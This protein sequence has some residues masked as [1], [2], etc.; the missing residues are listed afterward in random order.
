MGAGTGRDYEQARDR[1]V[2]AALHAG[3]LIAR[4]AGQVPEDGL[5]EKVHHD[6]VTLVDEEA[7]RL[8]LG[9]LHTAYPHDA[10]LAEEGAGEAV[11]AAAG[12]RWIID[13]IDG[14]ANFTHGVPPYA[15]SIGLEEANTMQ[16]GVVYDVARHELFTAIR[17][18]G[19]YVNG[20]RAH[21]SRAATLG[22]SLLATG[23]PFRAFPHLDTYLAVLGRLM[24]QTRGLRR[25]GAASVDLAYVACGRFDGF[26]EVGLS[27]WDVAAGSLLVTEGGGT[28]TNFHGLPEVLFTG[29]VLATNGLLHEALLAAMQPLADS[30]QGLFG[31]SVDRQPQHD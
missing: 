12:H 20:R 30:C 16:V 5:R 15:V 14:T 22:E 2:A 27:P 11:P 31:N 18:R 28:V 23:F 21:V 7:Q 3:R 6:L 10:F 8:L 24:Q 1:A 17:G 9:L 19:L 13:P 4:H 25:P 26:F 29:Q